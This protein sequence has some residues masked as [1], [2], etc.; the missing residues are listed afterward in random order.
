ME[1][2]AQKRSKNGIK[3]TETCRRPVGTSLA[4]N[5]LFCQNGGGGDIPCPVCLMGLFEAH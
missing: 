2:G 3:N 1:S 5:F 4:D